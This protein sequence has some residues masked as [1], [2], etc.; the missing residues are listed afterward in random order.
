MEIRVRV[1]D[2]LASQAQ[3]LGVP[4]EL[5]VERLLAQRASAT[6]ALPR[7]QTQEQIRAWLDALAQFSDKIPELPQTLSREWIYQDRD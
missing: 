1:P 6:S 5:Y 3:A 7:P 4:L 2:E